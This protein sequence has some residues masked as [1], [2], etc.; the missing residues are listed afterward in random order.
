MMVRFQWGAGCTVFASM[1]YVSVLLV[2]FVRLPAKI[3]T[4]K[5][6]NDQPD[7]SQR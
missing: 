5:Y 4:T 1:F 6:K 2:Y 7:F 3:K